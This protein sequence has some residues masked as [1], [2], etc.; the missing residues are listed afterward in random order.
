MSTHNNKTPIRF[1]LS[2]DTEE[3]WD[4]SGAFPQDNC[5]VDN[6]EHLPDFHNF[7]QELGIRPTYF[8]D[9]AVASNPTAAGTLKTIHEQGSCEIGAHLHPWCNPPYE[10]TTDEHRSHVINLPLDLVEKKLDKLSA[11][12]EKTFT[13]APRAFRTGRWGINGDVLALLNRKGYLIDSSVYPYYANKAFNCDRA[14]GTPYW[15]DLQDPLK[16]GEQ[17]EI[18]EIPVTAGF[19]RS[20]FPAWKRVHRALSAPPLSWLRLIGVLWH[21]QA[22]RKIYLSPELSSREDMVNLVEKAIKRGHRQVHMFMHSSSLLP[23][24]NCFEGQDKLTIKEDIRYVQQYLESRYEV[25][26]C[27]LSEFSEQAAP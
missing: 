7:C 15:P 20:H 14:P 27:T 12:L 10:G 13:K 19:N 4:W 11:L 2:V 24:A 26:Y 9:Y 1:L 18:F 6:V 21:T 25:E 8:V 22:L 17:R 23:N 16:I 3:E 5:S